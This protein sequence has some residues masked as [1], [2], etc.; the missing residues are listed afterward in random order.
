MFKKNSVITV[1]ILKNS[2][3]NLNKGVIKVDLNG[4]LI[5]GGKFRNIGYAFLFKKMKGESLWPVCRIFL[6]TG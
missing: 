5:I 1:V 2:K 3:N 6:M 4:M